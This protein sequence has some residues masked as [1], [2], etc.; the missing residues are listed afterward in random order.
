M[1]SLLLDSFVE[2]D[3]YHINFLFS[4]GSNSSIQVKE[5]VNSDDFSSGN[6]AT[7][8]KVEEAIEFY[9]A[10]IKDYV[11]IFCGVSKR[12]NGG[13]ASITPCKDSNVYGIVLKLT[14]SQLAKLDTYEGGYTREK[15]KIVC[16]S[17]MGKER[18]IEGYVYI[19]N[20]STFK[21][22]PSQSYMES[23]R[24]ML[25]ERRMSHSQK[26]TIRC[27]KDGIIKSIGIWEPEYGIKLLNI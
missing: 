8:K 4:Y 15:I 16:Q 7:S 22:L 26:I 11:R 24:S 6:A 3:S 10:Y 21:Y 27:I 17:I 18:V 14:N 19:K 2:K 20:E 23:I 13:I 5:R 12:W 9:P 25:D 1:S